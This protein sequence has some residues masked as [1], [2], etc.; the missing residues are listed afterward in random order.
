MSMVIARRS[1]KTSHAK[2]KNV[3]AI[4]HL[5]AVQ[6]CGEVDDW[7][8]QLVISQTTNWHLLIVIYC[9]DLRN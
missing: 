4:I 5:C 8:G 2:V 3:Y 6:D 7:E 9:L 1:T